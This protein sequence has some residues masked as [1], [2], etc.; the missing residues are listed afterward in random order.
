MIANAYDWLMWSD[1][2]RKHLDALVAVA[3][4]GT[5]GRA[6]SELGYTQSA[7]SQQI[8]ALEAT[9]GQTLFDRPAGP[10]RPTLT[11]A[12]K[13]ALRHARTVL[14]HLNEAE[15]DLN[16][17]ARGLAGELVIGT[18]QS[19]STRVLP[20][21]LRELYEQAPDAHVTLRGEA[22]YQDF[23]VQAL[24]AG[25]LDFAFAIGAVGDGLDSMYLGADPHVAVVPPD[26]APGPVP[27]AAFEDTPLVGQ[28]A[29]DT[30]GLIVDRQL[31]D[32]GISPDYAFRSHDNG[33]VQAMVGAGMGIALMPLL[34][35]EVA[36]NTTS[37][38]TVEPPLDPRE[39]SIIWPSKRPLSPLAE[40]FA[41]IIVDVCRCLLSDADTALTN[42]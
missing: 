17:F 19:I 37:V 23:G 33:A 18:F 5:F 13:I 7:V 22:T 15:Q 40:R 14:K 42:Y 41:N 39:L 9:V 30:C 35:V 27:V 20:A 38:R 12:G 31:E 24:H 34:S 32:H 2:A 25:E 4:H 16:R 26:F 36:S 28:P 1:L 29:D 11:P 8:A 21:A 3:D 6:A 10:S